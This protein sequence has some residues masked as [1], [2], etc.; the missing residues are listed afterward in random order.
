MTTHSRCTAGGLTQVKLSTIAHR[1]AGFTLV[2]LL[3]VITIIGILVALLLPAVNAARG[4]AMMTQCANNQRN[5]GLAML[6]FESTKGKFP[7]YVQPVKRNDGAYAT[8]AGTGM[9]NS[10]YGSSSA[11]GAGERGGSRVSWAARVLRNSN[12]KI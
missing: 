5:L 8:V 11:A 10:T 1:Q 9:A 6:N 4:R 3:V 12:G 7:G 2:E